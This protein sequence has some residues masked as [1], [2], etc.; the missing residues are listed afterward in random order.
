M[1]KNKLMDPYGRKFQKLAA[2][3]AL[4]HITI[5]QC[6]DCGHPVRDGYCCLNCGSENPTDYYSE[7]VYCEV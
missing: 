6:K 4:S 5:T 3:L 2:N 1:S 7:T